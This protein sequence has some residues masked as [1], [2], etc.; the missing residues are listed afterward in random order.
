MVIAANWGNLKGKSC[1]GYSHN[2]NC[3]ITIN[4]KRNMPLHLTMFQMVSFKNSWNYL[5]QHFQR[6]PF[7]PAETK[8][9]SFLSRK[10]RRK[11][12]GTKRK[13]LPCKHPSMHCHVLHEGVLLWRC[14]FAAPTEVLGDFCSHWHRQS[15]SLL[16]SPRMLPKPCRMGELTVPVLHT[17]LYRENYFIS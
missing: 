12:W 16:L 14:G 9:V 11:L 10:G 8:S 2:I 5:P 15:Q 6:K 17:D 4:W 7:S 1:N 13:M 3:I